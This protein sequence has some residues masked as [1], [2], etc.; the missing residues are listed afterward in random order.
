[1]TN[2]TKNTTATA[3][4]IATSKGKP[5]SVAL[6][7]ENGVLAH[8]I[9]ESPIHASGAKSACEPDTPVHVVDAGKFV[10]ITLR[11]SE[12]QS[13]IADAVPDPDT[14]HAPATK[15]Q[16]VRGLPRGSHNA[17]AAYFSCTTQR[18]PAADCVA[19]ELLGTERDPVRVGV[20]E[21]VAAP[22]TVPVLLRVR[23]WVTVVVM[24][25]DEVLLNVCVGTQRNVSASV[26]LTGSPRQTA[27]APTVCG[28]WH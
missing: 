28:Q 12:A 20:G 18:E 9:V 13:T 8:D 10:T 6:A 19:L 11:P 26:G 1:M 24:D 3:M 2:A 27:L 15:F 23:V 4:P 14:V 25:C 17:P 7:T 5:K 16:Y 22:D 21:G